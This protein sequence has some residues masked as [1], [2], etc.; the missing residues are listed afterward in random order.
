MEGANLTSTTETFPK[1]LLSG[2]CQIVLHD[3]IGIKPYAYVLNYGN[4]QGS[5]LCE[6]SA[7]KFDFE[8]EA[9]I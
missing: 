3:Q 8:V 5:N 1:T 2:I 4:F 9:R 7:L 6:I